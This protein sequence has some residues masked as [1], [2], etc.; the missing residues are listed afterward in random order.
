MNI[1]RFIK[2]RKF[3]FKPYEKYGFEV[4]LMEHI[5][6]SPNI[7][8]DVTIVEVPTRD[9][10]YWS[11]LRVVNEEQSGYEVVPDDLSRIEKY[12]IKKV[13]RKR[14]KEIAPEFQEEI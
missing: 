9:V 2:P 13:I 4:L 5:P 10:P 3:L 7:L 6:S 1:L 12:Y 11:F 14:F 8:S